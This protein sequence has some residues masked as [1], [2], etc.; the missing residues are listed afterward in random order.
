MLVYRLKGIE[1]LVKAPHHA[2]VEEP[3]MVEPLPV[4]HG[5][6]GFIECAALAAVAEARL[7]AFKG[8]VG[9]VKVHKL[10]FLLPAY[11]EGALPSL[12]GFLTAYFL[13]RVTELVTSSQL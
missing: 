7:D 1:L 11:G 13:Y 10:A 5:G 6:Q 4:N 8:M 12:T 3:A 9:D 2:L